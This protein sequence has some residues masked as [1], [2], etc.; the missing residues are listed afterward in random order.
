MQERAGCQVMG[1]KCNASGAWLQLLLQLVAGGTNGACLIEGTRKSK[2]RKK[3]GGGGEGGGGR[4]THTRARSE[5]R[6]NKRD[7]E[8]NSSGVVVIV[9]PRERQSAVPRVLYG[10]KC[11]VERNENAVP[12]TV[13]G[14]R[15]YICRSMSSLQV[16]AG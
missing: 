7:R 12:C 8:G 5:T 10:R 11:L 15:L 4:T 1:G 6:G 14:M 13:E 3:R 9:A 16:E 2:K